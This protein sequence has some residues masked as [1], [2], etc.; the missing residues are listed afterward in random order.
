MS[1]KKSG[2]NQYSVEIY[3]ARKT[4]VLELNAKFKIERYVYLVTSILSLA[5][6]VYL[7]ID[8]YQ[9]EKIDF[10]QLVLLN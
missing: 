5:L 1:E 9:N 8:L 7:A 10:D 2:D 4:I 3:E 6:I